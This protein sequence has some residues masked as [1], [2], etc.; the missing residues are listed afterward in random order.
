M[1]N[2]E[3]GIDTFGLQAKYKRINKNVSADQTLSPGT[4][5]QEETETYNN[6]AATG[7]RMTGAIKTYLDV[8]YEEE[9][10]AEEVTTST[11]VNTIESIYTTL[12]NKTQ[13]KHV[14][15][16]EE[17]DLKYN[18]KNFWNE[19]VPEAR[20]YWEN[21]LHPI[22]IA[23]RGNKNKSFLEN[24]K[25]NTLGNPFDW[26]KHGEVEATKMF[27]DWV[28]TGNNY[29][30]TNATKE[31]RQTLINDFKS[32]KWKGSVILYYKELN[33]PSHATVIDYFANEYEWNNV[34]PSSTTVEVLSESP[35]ET[36]ITYTPKGKTEQVYVV[37]GSKVFNKDGKEVFKE[38]GVDRNKIFANLA[39][40]Q[41]RGVVVEYDGAKYIVNNKEQILSGTTGKLMQWNENNGNRIAILK[42]ASDKFAMNNPEGLPSI[43][44]TAE[45]CSS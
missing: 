34:I 24:Y 7:K 11:S 41:K 42:L 32:G 22:L 36:F 26:Q 21:P 23:Y 29:G 28:I 15:L 40:K 44:R 19:I 5:N 1:S 12:G 14:S 16:P 10:P 38:N 31:F 30:E 17:L 8:A 3:T 20:A 35:K 45:D 2:L 33:R 6:L 43:D 18:G 9:T 39:V 13:S 25:N 4:L 37:R 27:I